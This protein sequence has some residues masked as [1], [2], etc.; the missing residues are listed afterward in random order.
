ML[1]LLCVCLSV[2]AEITACIETLRFKRGEKIKPR[3]VQEVGR[4]RDLGR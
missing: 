1:L 3:E 4:P 2:N